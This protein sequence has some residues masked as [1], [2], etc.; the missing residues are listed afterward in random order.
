M[1]STIIAVDLAKSVFQVAVSHRPGRVAESHRLKR[2]EFVR[3][4]AQRQPA[5]VLLEACG[6]AHF[7]GRQ[8]QS[9]GH[10]VALLPSLACPPLCPRRQDRQCRCQSVAR[11]APQRADSR[12]S[13]QVDCTTNLDRAAP[14]SFGM[15]GG[16]NGAAQ[17]HPLNLARV[18]ISDSGRSSAGCPAHVGTD[19]RKRTGDSRSS[20]ACTRRGLPGDSGLRGANQSGREAA[21]DP[22]P[23]NSRDRT[24]AIHPWC[25]TSDLDGP[26]WVCGRRTTL[27]EQSTLRQL[28][29]AYTPR[30]IQWP[31]ATAR[32]DQQ[33]G[34]CL[35]PHAPDSRCA[36][37][38]LR[39]EACKAARS[40]PLLGTS[41]R[42]AQGS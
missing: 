28:P 42:K 25:G 38:T 34:R 27:S 29:R 32:R 1:K 31:R 15:A 20:P 37:N 5:L 33:A 2:A 36:R 24:S 39:R 4:F 12:S 13:S 17:S 41:C 11:S 23:P 8:L 26:R 10:R 40:A 16:A 22:R 14:A 9:M 18:W 35:H 21:P 3:F 7:W 19:R 6:T 30:A